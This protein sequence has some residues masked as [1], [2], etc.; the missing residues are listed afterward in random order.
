MTNLNET[1]VYHMLQVHY[2]TCLTCAD[3]FDERDALL[4][5][6]NNTDHASQL[7]DKTVWNQPQ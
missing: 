2:N 3:K 5:H 6:L 4:S 1:V 7:P